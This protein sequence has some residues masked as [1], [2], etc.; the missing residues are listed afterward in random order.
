MPTKTKAAKKERPTVCVSK[1]DIANGITEAS[2]CPIAL[3][4]RRQFKLRRHEV[5]VDQAFIRIR[6]CTY[7][8]P[9][10]AAKF[11]KKF[12]DENDEAETIDSYLEETVMGYSKRMLCEDKPSGGKA[13]KKHKVKP[14]EFKLPKA[15]ELFKCL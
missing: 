9:A 1:K 15:I 5:N 13:A 11:I 10:K 12:D 4:L 3:S 8:T 6:Q 7:A 14:I 2:S